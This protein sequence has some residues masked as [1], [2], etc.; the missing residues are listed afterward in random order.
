MKRCGPRSRWVLAAFT[1]AAVNLSALAACG[2]RTGLDLLPFAP[3]LTSPDASLPDGEPDASSEDSSPDVSTPMIDVDAP[4]PIDAM[5][6][7]GLLLCPD[8]GASL[9]YLWGQTGTLYT[10][11]PATLAAQPL[12]VVV[13]PTTETP[14][15]LSVSRAGFAYMM[16]QDWNIYRVDLATLAC[17]AT[18]YQQGQ[19]GFAGEGAI[20][21]SR[22][23]AAERLYVYGMNGGAAPVLAVTD[24][25]SF[26]LTAV[27]P[28]SP[29]PNA[30]PVDMQA[31][32]FGRL[33]VLSESGV[34]IQLDAATAG[35][36]G[37]NQTT[38]ETA[39]SWAVMTW[40][41]Q[42]YFFGGSEVSLYNLATQ[43]LLPLGVVAEGDSIVGASAVACIH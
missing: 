13:C 5:T 30:F 33:F 42:I 23:E 16:Y 20:A 26:V 32:A 43:E 2:S 24:L 12:G 4:P 39:N 36:L 11:D 9:A 17:E 34:L 3:S 7:D 14:W 28:V 15:T 18:P 35:V 6:P 29:N 27:G 1:G 25:T 38:F 8:G 19:L 10:F 41:D 37:Q 21:V 40:N 31:D 22:G